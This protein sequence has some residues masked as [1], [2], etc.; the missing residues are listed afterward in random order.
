MSLR[1]T[2]ALT[3]PACARDPSVSVPQV[4][5]RDIKPANLLIDD[6]WNLK[7]C[8]FG[9]AQVEDVPG[10]AA[11]NETSFGTPL[12]MPPEC[13]RPSNSAVNGRQW[14]IFS[15]GIV[16]WWMLERRPAFGANTDDVSRRYL[17]G[18]RP[19]FSD[20]TPVYLQPLLSRMWHDDSQERPD[21]TEVLAVLN[22]FQ[23]TLP[24]RGTSVSSSNLASSRPQSFKKFSS[25]MRNSFMGGNA[26]GTGFRS[27]SREDGSGITEALLSGSSDGD[28]DGSGWSS[29]SGISSRQRQS[30]SQ[31]QSEE[32]SDLELNRPSAAAAGDGPVL[33][34]E[35][36]A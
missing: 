13:H 23:K 20:E 19:A 30:Q 11:L 10:S 24:E 22:S 32:H 35:G 9:I 16:F 28:G 3:R 15:S 17:N 2:P 26:N 29:G 12:Y 36:Y 31:S 21:P 8:D 6:N 1:Q 5:H 25:F 18:E 27:R 7:L 14:D 33:T 34:Q 4:V